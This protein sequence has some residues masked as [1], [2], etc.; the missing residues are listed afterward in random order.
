MRLFF[1]GATIF[2]GRASQDAQ[3]T[4]AL[5]LPHLQQGFHDQVEPE[6]APVDARVTH[7]QAF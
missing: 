7:H 2:V 3:G 5:Y 4:T 6:A 1:L